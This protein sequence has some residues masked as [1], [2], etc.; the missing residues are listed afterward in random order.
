MKK[1]FFV[2]NSVDKNEKKGLL[3]LFFCLLCFLCF[4]VF[5]L[6]IDLSKVPFFLAREKCGVFILRYKNS[7]T[8]IRARIGNAPST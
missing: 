7:I 4:L 5:F 1:V 8:S 3:C 6:F 2:V